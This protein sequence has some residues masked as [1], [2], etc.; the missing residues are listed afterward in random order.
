VFDNV[1]YPLRVGKR[2]ARAAIR[3]RVEEALTL[4]GLEQFTQ[5]RATQLSGG[6]QQRLSLARALVR[7]PKVL[8]LDEPLSNLDATL[9]EQMRTEL[10]SIQRRLKIAT[11]FV[12]HDQ[13]E[14]LSMSNRVAV[15]REGVIVQEGT[16]RE[17]Y[18]TPNSEFVARFVGL[19]SFLHGTAQTDSSGADEPAVEMSFG[20]L[21]VNTHRRIAPGEAVTIVIRPEDVVVN[22]PE[23]QTNDLN[24]FTG[25]IEAGFFVGDGVDLR[26]RLGDDVIRAVGPGRMRLRRGDRVEVTL[27]P[28]ACTL[29][30]DEPTA[31][32]VNE[33]VSV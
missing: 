10:R 30:R 25:E 17:I 12:T 6:Q 14:A 24:T 3:D 15:M 32:S 1:A 21:Q 26:V 31:G 19:A 27:P 13:V 33:V 16:P 7:Q 8:L 5:R 9:R 28:E 29:L 23:R 18:Q 2:M 4:V 20:T 11:L 22:S